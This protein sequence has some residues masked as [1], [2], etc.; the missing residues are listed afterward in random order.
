ML[1]L[2]GQAR[3]ARAACLFFSSDLLNQLTA[4][5]KELD[6]DVEING[7]QAAS[8]WLNEKLALIGEARKK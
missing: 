4:M 3:A 2:F 1:Q 5:Q 8:V 7:I 6:R